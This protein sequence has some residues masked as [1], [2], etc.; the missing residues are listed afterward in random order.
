MFQDDL[1]RSLTARV[2]QTRDDRARVRELVRIGQWM[3]AEPSSDRVLGYLKSLKGT[4][5]LGA[6]S[7]KGDTVDF[8]AVSFLVEGAQVRRS[9]A[10][11]E[12]VGGGSSE[13]GT[14]FLIS[15]RL[16]LTNQH[17]I[18]DAA[19]ARTAQITFDR[20]M[21]ETGRPQRTT[22]FLLDPA[23]FALFSEHDQLDYAL[24]AVGDR[25]TGD[26]AL[27]ELGC[28]P[29]SN[30]PDRHVLGMNVN[31]IQHPN[32]LPKMISVRNNLLT[33]RTPHTL[34][35]ETDTEEGSSGS[36]VFNDAWEVVALHHW[37]QPFL[38]L[39]DD[40]GTPIPNTVNEGVRITA[41]Y[42]DLSARL[43]MLPAPQRT[44]LE[45]AL[46]LGPRAE[47]PAHL[48]GPPRPRSTTPESLRP[49]PPREVPMNR[50]GEGREPR[51]VIP[52]E[53]HLRVGAAYEPAPGV[54][55]RAS[56]SLVP[57]AGRTLRGAEGKHLDKDYTN[58]EGYDAGHIP[59]HNVPLPKLGAALKQDL[60]PLRAGEPSAAAG[61]LKYVHFSV[62]LHRTRRMAI[63]TATNIDG[64]TY[65]R[66]DR[67]T[68]LV[69][70]TDEGET[71]YI[72]PRVGRSSFL[73]QTFYGAWSNY[74]DKG[75]LTR[76]TD[77]TWGTVIE[78]ESA[79]ADT[80]HFTNCSPQHFRFNE[81]VPFWQ[82]AERY[83]L[84]NGTLA[85]DTRKPITVFQGPI[86]NDAVDHTAEDVQIPSSFFKVIAWKGASGLKAV[87]L[88]V[89]QLA[90]LG[91]Q[92]VFLGEPQDVPS[93]DVAQWRVPIPSI[94]ARTGLD[95]G[96]K[97]RAA[98]TIATGVQ[99]AVGGEAQKRLRALSD[100]LG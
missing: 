71:W 51:L 14:G 92:R 44:L 63:F 31:I 90:L 68:G 65:L 82:G 93:V 40:A 100:I 43:A 3:R 81:S 28:C 53:I 74:F 56:A 26:V 46:V 89:D 27:A 85:Q 95:F 69:V 22:S 23:A 34:L 75:H 98:D 1:R 67:K 60:V 25:Q 77:P 96:A 61:E 2:E 80:F 64:A 9:V 50:N 45:D 86:F 38:E 18:A 57:A 29:L 72:D 78:A 35:Y 32:G 39:R 76:R 79:N 11:V 7:L 5:P 87:G 66:V 15:P 48:L 37:G 16:F 41:I 36:P 70:N 59:G 97:I 21:D 99:P 84:E 6:E 94:E 12:V 83:V 8:Q 52:I 55:V 10:F 88:V 62:K 73:D 19:A 17:V 49:S 54:T 47:P 42:E 20:E 33:H 91:E 4:A 58:R 13:V 24:V 30:S